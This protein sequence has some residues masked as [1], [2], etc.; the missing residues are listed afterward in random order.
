MKPGDA[1]AVTS[2]GCEIY[3]ILMSMKKKTVSGLDTEVL[4]KLLAKRADVEFACLF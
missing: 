1:E 2:E 4:E 3:V